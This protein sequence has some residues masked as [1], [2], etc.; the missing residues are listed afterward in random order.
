MPNFAVD[1]GRCQ[2]HMQVDFERPPC[3]FGEGFGATVIIDRPVAVDAP[4]Y[5]GAYEV[6]PKFTEKVLPTKNHLMQD[7]V[8]VNA[9]EVQRVSNTAGGRTV[10]IGGLINGD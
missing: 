4:T 7:D 5:T 8:T 2:R 6:D 9:I 3:E 10:Y 1:F